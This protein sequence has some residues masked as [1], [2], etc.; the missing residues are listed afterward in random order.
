MKGHASASTRV[1]L[2][3]SYLL[4]ALLLGAA[5]LQFWL[6]DAF[7][8]IADYTEASF[9]RF[10]PD[11]RSLLL[12]IAGGTVALFTGPVQLWT[13]LRGRVPR[14]HRL[15]GYAYVAGIAMSASS[16]FYLAFHTQ[17]AF[18]LSLFILAIFWCLT[19]TMAFVAVRNDRIDVHRE[20]M[21]RS[22]I[23]T[24]SFV[25]YRFLV[26]LSMFRPLGSSRDATVLWIS[27]VV[28][29]MVFELWLQRDRVRPLGR[30]QRAE[31][32][33]PKAAWS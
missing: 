32:S 3:I 7:P 24:F 6:H 10:W 1:T 31:Q 16:S 29:M 26:G 14:L 22:Y 28:P 25:A 17:P 8:Y 23:L 11:R 13:G 27:W 30:S 12:H 15:T 5:A 19:V 21:I 9:G 33:P 4:T 20:W 2:G 18:G